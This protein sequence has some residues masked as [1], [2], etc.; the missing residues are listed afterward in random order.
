MAEFKTNV[1]VVQKDPVVTVEVA[2]GSPFP[3]GPQRFR[4]IVV[5][6]AGN[7][8]EPAFLDV[9]VRDT[10]RPTAVI[11]VVNADGKV[12]EP[13]VPQGSSFIL[14]GSRSSDV[15]PGKVKE[16]RFTLLD[17]V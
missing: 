11:D 7:E 3:A 13:V 14:S 8:S 5:D 4:L 2:G 6:D 10:E 15:E 17:R 1:P 16:Y 9:I 12:I